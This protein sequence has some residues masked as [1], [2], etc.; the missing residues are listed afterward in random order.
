M[1]KKKI[2]KKKLIRSKDIDTDQSLL[3]SRCLFLFGAVDT[4][5]TKELVKNLL[6]LDLKSQKPIALY[7]NSPG[8]NIADGFGIIDIMN[9][10]RSPVVTVIVGKAC[11]MAGLISV[12]GHKR[13]I[14]KDSVWMG[15][16]GATSMEDYFPFIEDRMKLIKL[17]ENKIQSILTNNT[18]LSSR[19]I[20][21]VLNSGEL[22]FDAKECK[23]KG[24]VDY[25]VR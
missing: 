21:K 11:S 17:Y 3:Q 14:S 16:P 2:K 19:E 22:W 10:L 1:S 20:S 24:I 25:I 7:I 5:S 9:K 6:A 18:K 4:K 15:H 23:E 12:V 13:L 8:G